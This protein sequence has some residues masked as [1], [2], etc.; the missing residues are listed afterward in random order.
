MAFYSRYMDEPHRAS[1]N[2]S[3]NYYIVPTQC[4]NCKFC[5]EIE[6]NWPI[7]CK[8]PYS[9]EMP[10]RRAFK[11]GNRQYD[12]CKFFKEKESL[13]A[14]SFVT[15]SFSSSTS[16]CSSFESYEEETPQQRRERREREREERERQREEEE[17]LEELARQ[18]EER[19]AEEE[20]MTCP[21]C[22]NRV[23]EGFYIDFH[24]SNFHYECKEKFAN[25]AEGKKWIEKKLAEEKELELQIQ[26]EI[27]I[28]EKEVEKDKKWL[29]S[30]KAGKKCAAQ[31]NGISDDDLEWDNIRNARLEYEKTKIEVEEWA[32]KTESGKKNLS[33]CK[34]T[35]ED[36]RFEFLNSA[37]KAAKEA[38]KKEKELLE[39][40]KNKY[41]ADF[42]KAELLIGNTT[43]FEQDGKRVNEFLKSL[44][45]NFND[46]NEA[47][48]QKILNLDFQNP[49]EPKKGLIIAGIILII[50]V[51]LSPLGIVLLT[52][53]LVKRRKSVKAMENAA[54]NNYNLLKEIMYEKFTIEGD[55]NT[56]EKF[57]KNIASEY[58][59][60]FISRELDSE[61][62]EKIILGKSDESEIKK[63][64]DSFKLQ[65]DENIVFGYDDT[66][67]KSFKTG[68]VLTDKKLYFTDGNS[69][70]KNTSIPVN[71]IKK[72]G[73]KKRL[74]VPNICF[75]DIFISITSPIGKDSEKLCE[76]LSKAVMILKNENR[77]EN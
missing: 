42:E 6:S 22:G 21:Y 48:L 71:E 2:G 54:Q 33:E 27:E 73:Y 1:E 19:R 23:K 41:S 38:E 62:V 47:K 64:K 14:E 5:E 70:S 72:I 49:S 55:N 36:L 13:K 76:M 3:S 74:G 58:C 26:R 53:G 44:K 9:S 65:N 69:F 29:S 7:R 60:K 28:E 75:N 61:T 43:L 12:V 66:M 39:S 18:E 24:G 8:A 40:K 17:R 25:S 35:D 37:Y 56:S 11:E 67:K 46:S 63:A 77:E 30:T 68:F 32:D 20:R 15:S 16:S 51:S 45:H 4:P 57:V 10:S 31:Y 59:K 52:V 50:S 34:E